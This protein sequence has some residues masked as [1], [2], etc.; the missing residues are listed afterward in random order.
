MAMSEDYL[1][2]V[3]DQLGGAG[4][5]HMRKMFGGVGIYLDGVIFAL[6]AYD[7][8]Y[9]KVDDKNRPDF[10]AQ[11]MGPF[12]PFGEGSYAMGYYEVPAEVLED[13]DELALWAGKAVEVSLR[14]RVR[15][16]GK[17]RSKPPKQ[18]A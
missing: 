11:G 6:I 10:E 9:F 8:L 5:V 7:T 14:S 17:G 15:K 18:K 16:R 1:E 3:K 13:R 4:A 12:V 2:Y